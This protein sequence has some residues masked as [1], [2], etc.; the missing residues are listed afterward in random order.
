M[1]YQCRARSQWITA[2]HSSLLL[3]AGASFRSALIW[4]STIAMTSFVA[5]FIFA[6]QLANSRYNFKTSNS[7][8]L[9]L[10][11]LFLFLNLSGLGFINIFDS[12]NHFKKD[13]D[14]VYHVAR[15]QTTFWLH[16]LLHY[17]IS[18]R[19]APFILHISAS[20]LFL[21]LNQ[22]KRN[23]GKLS[24]NTNRPN[25]NSLSPLSHHQSDSSTDDSL[26][27]DILYGSDSLQRNRRSSDS[28][29][30]RSTKSKKRN[31]KP[32]EY[33][34]IG[35]LIALLIPLQH[36]AFFSIAI[37]Y[38]S[39]VSFAI[40]QKAVSK[41]QIQSQISYQSLE[42]LIKLKTFLVDLLNIIFSDF[43]QYFGSNDMTKMFIG[44]FL[45][46]A[47]PIVQYRVT[48]MDVSWI[49]CEK[50]WDTLTQD[51]FIFPSVVL[52]FRNL[53]LFPFFSLFLIWPLLTPYHIKVLLPS[54]VVFI[55]GNYLSFQT[56]P[57]NNFLFLYPSWA[58]ITC[59]YVPIAL[60]RF[61]NIH[62]LS[63][64]ENQI[65]AKEATNIDNNTDQTVGND[66]TINPIEH[67]EPIKRENTE[68][69]VSSESNTNEEIQGFFLALS[70]FFIICCTVSSILGLYKQWNRTIQFWDQNVFELVQFVEENIPTDAIF[71]TPDN[72][73]NPIPI[74]TGRISYNS[75]PKNLFIHNYIWFLQDGDLKQFMEFPDSEILP[76]VQY[77]LEFQKDGISMKL[78]QTRM[79]NAW[80]LCFEHEYI[81]LY[82]RTAVEE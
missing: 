78:N 74:L 52:W 45:V 42:I 2:Y 22:N 69:T 14:F 46:S 41:V 80:K 76:Q 68:I 48:G 35:I 29:E 36:Q 44:F 61:S 47:I 10:I 81:N 33:P 53:G 50:L 79:Q 26:F 25:E 73:I 43:C 71:L 38:L 1:C 31:E 23:T 70:I 20:I 28:F 77:Y 56:L 27:D 40:L 17:I 59:I 66:T 12:R 72:I 24:T 51:G 4:P 8:F 15:S 18:Y 75:S 62:F 30:N 57:Q 34:I 13:I 49:H 9:P 6:C 5:M 65:K 11:S 54:L 63:D 37:Y 67:S 39:Y 3:L 32:K 55:F 60:K 64:E 58:L 7:I 16:P 21:L 19:S 82:N